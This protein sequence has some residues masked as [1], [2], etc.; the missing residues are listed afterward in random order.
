MPPQA[1]RWLSRCHA[2][3]SEN[4]DLTVK[5]MGQVPCFPKPIAGQPDCAVA[6]SVSFPSVGPGSMPP[7]VKQFLALHTSFPDSVR[8]SYRSVSVGCGITGKY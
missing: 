6:V 4:L 5:Q 1:V 3:I 8:P 2:Q 7:Y